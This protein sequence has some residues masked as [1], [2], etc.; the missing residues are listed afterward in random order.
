MPVHIDDEGVTFDRGASRDRVLWRD[1]V[2]VAIETSDQGPWVED[3]HF[4]LVPRAGEPLEIPQFLGTELLDRLQRLPGF[5]NEQVIQAMMCTS[6]ARF[7]C[8]RAP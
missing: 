1:L 8:W 7:V 3:V 4:V 2:E 5:D 6:D